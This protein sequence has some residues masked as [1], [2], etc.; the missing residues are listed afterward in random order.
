MKF[1]YVKIGNF[2][3]PII[4]LFLCRC[5]VRMHTMALVDS[6]ADSC[7]FDAQ[8]AAALDIEELEDGIQ[9]D[10]ESVSGHVLHA[11]FHEV[12]LEIGGNRLPNV[13]IAFS[14]EM[15]DNAMNILGQQGFFGIC[16]IKFT[17]TKREIELMTGTSGTRH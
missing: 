16:P 2:Y 7:I 8:F 13:S 1:P 6:G 15:P 12:D 11:F 5:D 3:K 9:A 4:P 14:R 10:F 17:Y